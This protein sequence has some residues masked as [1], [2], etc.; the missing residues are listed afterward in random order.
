MLKVNKNGQKRV[1]TTIGALHSCGKGSHAPFEQA[2]GQ[3]LAFIVHSR[4]KTPSATKKIDTAISTII[5]I[6]SLKAKGMDFSHAPAYIR[7]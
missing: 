4:K 5:A 3:V 7:E 6:K 2:Q 1:T